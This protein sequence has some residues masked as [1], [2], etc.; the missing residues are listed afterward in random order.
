MSYRE[1]KSPS[2]ACQTRTAQPGDFI[3]VQITQA[4]S[5]TLHA[6]PL[7][8]TTIADFNIYKDA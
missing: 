2:E 7:H 6:N 1:M 3:A 8:H 5:V 4:S